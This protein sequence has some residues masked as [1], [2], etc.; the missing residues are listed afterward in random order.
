MGQ[1][2]ISLYSRSRRFI[3]FR[4]G[5]CEKISGKASLQVSSPSTLLNRSVYVVFYYG[6][7][8]TSSFSDDLK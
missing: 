6:K 2:I 4:A 5:I 8:R 7:T 1:L 3:E